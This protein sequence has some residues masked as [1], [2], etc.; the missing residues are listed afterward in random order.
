MRKLGSDSHAYGINDIQNMNKVYYTLS[1]IE[2]ANKLTFYYNDSINKIQ[3]LFAEPEATT[4]F[5][6]RLF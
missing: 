1:S 4:F 3:V 2:Q 5:L 6:Q